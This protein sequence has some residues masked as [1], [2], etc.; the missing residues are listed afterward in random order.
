MNIIILLLVFA[1]VLTF[2]YALALF[3][4]APL[5][6]L[7]GRYQKRQVDKIGS[8]LEDSFIGVDRKRIIIFSSLPLML[9]IFFLIFRRNLLGVG[10]VVAGLIFSI[11]LPSLAVRMIKANRLRKFTSQLVD[12]LIILSSSLKAGLSFIQTMEVLCEEMPPPISQE[13]G[14]VLKETKIGVNLEDSLQAL[15]KRMYSEELNLIITSILVARETG[16][17]LTTVFSRLVENIR[18]NIKLKEKITT[19][20]LQGRLQGMIMMVLPVIFGFFI[21]KQAPDHFDVMFQ[22]D[23][24]KFLIALAIFLQIVGMIVIKMVSTIRI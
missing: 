13:F 16:G 10:G 7:A 2:G 5:V 4:S 18:D 17:E 23:L 19:L 1:A 22:T 12:A 8:S 3:L 11:T 20:T 14:L 21:W 6:N 15:R 24:G 9:T